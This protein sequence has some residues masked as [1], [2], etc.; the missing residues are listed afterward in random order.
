MASKVGIMPDYDAGRAAQPVGCGKEAGSGAGREDPERPK[1]RRRGQG[2]CRGASGARAR[3]RTGAVGG[4]GRPGRLGGGQ[5]MEARG[6]LRGTG[7]GVRALGEGV[8]ASLVAQ[9]VKN[10]P[11]MRETRA[12]PLS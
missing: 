3:S 2:T 7:I 12:S 1:D 5:G 8:W 4:E 11:A 9:L 10:P 6:V